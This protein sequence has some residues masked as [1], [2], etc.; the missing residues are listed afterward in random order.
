MSPARP[1]PWPA[2][3]AGRF[4]CRVYKTPRCRCR[5]RRQTMGDAAFTALTTARLV[6]RR[7]RSEDLDAFVA[8]RSDPE[9]A[10]YQSWEAPYRPSQARQFLQELEAIHPDTPRRM[11]P[12]RGCPAAHGS[13]DRRLWGPRLYRGFTPGRDWLHP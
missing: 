4:D 7:F 2:W 1:Y 9:T 11:V 10:R 5:Q 13:A 3:P 12:V 6:L 8:Y